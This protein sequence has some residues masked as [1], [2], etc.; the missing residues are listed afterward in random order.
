MRKKRVPGR[1]ANPR[2]PQITSLPSY[3]AAQLLP[4][5]GKRKSTSLI[6]VSYSPQVFEIFSA[7]LKLK[8]KKL[9]QDR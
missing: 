9:P 2:G 8:S 4:P 1:K 6:L 7:G 3:L 5:L